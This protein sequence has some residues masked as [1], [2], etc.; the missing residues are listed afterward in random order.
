MTIH[1]TVGGSES[2]RAALVSAQIGVALA[3]VRWPENDWR[4]LVETFAWRLRELL[5]EH[6]FVLEAHRQSALDG[7]GAEALV[8][9]I[10]NSLK[11]AGLTEKE[12]VWGYASLHDFVTGHVAL[13]MGRARA[14]E[15]RTG[16]PSGT[17]ALFSNYRDED[18]RFSG[19]VLVLV[20]G[21]SS[22][23]VRNTST[24]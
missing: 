8:V 6:P 10:V 4:A 17:A 23:I 20:E 14:E 16:A 11:D 12:A 1:R 13:M 21:L 22:L 24:S 18:E 15:G 2:L 5:Y 7:P 19:G 9:R 3:H